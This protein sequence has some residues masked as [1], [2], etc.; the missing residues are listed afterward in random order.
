MTK[1][2]VD[3]HNRVVAETDVVY[4]LGDFSFRTKEYV[5]ADLLYCLNGEH[6]LIRGNHDRWTNTKFL[7]VGFK[8]VNTHHFIEEDGIN[9]LAIHTPRP[10]LIEHVLKADIVLCGHVHESWKEKII[11]GKLHINVG[12][13]VWDFT[14]VSLGEVV[15][16]IKQ[17]GDQDV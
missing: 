13:D 2:I 7:R 11:S 5:V 17:K 1:A 15:E 3:N 6:H 14:P 4:H 10:N 9:L 16:T 8:S 12:V